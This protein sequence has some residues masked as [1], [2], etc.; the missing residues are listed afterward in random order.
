M[1][2]SLIRGRMGKEYRL[3][4]QLGPLKML[5]SLKLSQ[6]PW[7]RWFPCQRPLGYSYASWLCRTDRMLVSLSRNP[8]SKPNETLSFDKVLENLNLRRMAIF[9]EGIQSG[10]RAKIPTKCRM[11]TPCLHLQPKGLQCN[12]CSDHGFLSVGVPFLGR[13]GK[14]GGH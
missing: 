8:T 4:R 2:E 9:L 12:D 13:K 3:P 7:N 5:I 10:Q 1:N 11:R 6:D 14:H